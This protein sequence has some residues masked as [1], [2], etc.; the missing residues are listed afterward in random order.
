MRKRI[1]TVTGALALSF[2]AACGPTSADKEASQLDTTNERCTP[3]KAGGDLVMGTYTN[4]PGLDPVSPASEGVFGGTELTAIYDTLMAWNPQIAEYE[5]RL[6]ESMTPDPTYTNWTMRLR[7]GV[8][9]GNGDP[10]TSD[11]VK[12]SIQRHL[13][14]D[15]VDKSRQLALNIS[16]IEVPDPLTVNFTLT[17]PW[18]GFPYVLATDVGMVTNPRVVQERGADFN[19][20]PAGAGVGPYEVEHFTPGEEV[21]LTAKSDYWGGPVCVQQLRFVSIAGAKGSYEAFENKEI[22]LAFLREPQVIAEAREDGFFDLPTLFGATEAVVMNNGSGATSSAPITADLRIRQAIA[23]AIDVEQINQRVFDGQALAS[24]RLTPETAESASSEILDSPHDPRSAKQLVA[25]V[26]KEGWN[27]SIRLLSDKSPTHVQE[28]IAIKAQLE[29]AGFEVNLDNS[30]DTGQLSQRIVVEGNYDLAIYGLNLASEGLW[31]RLA[32]RLT[33]GSPTNF[34]QYSD[35]RMD[36]AL[37]A[38]KVAASFDERRAAIEAIEQ[39]WDAT[40]PGVAL[41]SY[42]ETTIVQPH[43]KGIQLTRGAILRFENAYLDHQ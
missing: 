26:K 2:C 42:E 17:S 37:A 20:N 32:P 1:L 35:P 11:A 22:D 18:P 10:F 31:A 33:T 29:A 14:T 4:S 28:S 16:S 6:A 38:L 36:S 30:V 39:V 13:A 15:N 7:A 43:V 5:P 25:E 21:V 24:T 3:Q 8:K 27:G 23:A 12:S 40:V 34:Y 19:N 41:A 9:F